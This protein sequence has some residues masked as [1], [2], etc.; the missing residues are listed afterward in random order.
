MIYEL[1][2]DIKMAKSKKI[3]NGYNFKR[4]LWTSLKRSITPIILLI[5]TAVIPLIPVEYSE[6]TVG[7]FCIYIGN[8]VYN[9]IKN[10]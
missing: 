9:W 10:K 1:L 8:L 3:W 2:E 6:M 4:G 5:I 7:A